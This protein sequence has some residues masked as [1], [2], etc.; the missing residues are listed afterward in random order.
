MSDA[1]IS[2]PLLG[3]GFVLDMPRYFTVFGLRLYWYGVIIAL[4]FILGVLYAV[5]VRKRF[6]L[7]EEN[8][9][10]FVLWAVPFA[11]IGARL[12]HVVFNWADFKDNPIDIVKIWEGGSGIFGALLFVIITICVFSRVKKIKVGALMDVSA[13][14]LLIGQAVGRWG[15]FV[16]RELYGVATDLPWKM[17]LT[18]PA[19]TIYVHPLFLYESIWNIIGFIILHFLSKKRR[20]DGEIFARY[21][22]W[23]CFGRCLCESIRATHIYYVNFFGHSVSASMIVS[24]G[25]LIISVIFLLINRFAI[26]HDPTELYALKNSKEK[27]SEAK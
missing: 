24:A 26:K 5:K 15:N 27:K 20:Y 22:A 16:N 17:G 2:F 14:G 25:V 12:Y 21:L 9:I 18:T 6:G 11:I 7:S 3:D 4:G 23:Y 10:D 8:I 13:L 1:L 19:E